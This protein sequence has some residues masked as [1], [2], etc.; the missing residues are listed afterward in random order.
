MI[1]S[2]KKIM[3]AVVGLILL[4]TASITVYSNVQL[5][6]TKQILSNVKN[7]QDAL[8][9][10]EAISLANSN[11]LIAILDENLSADEKRDQLERTV[12]KLNTILSKDEI[13]KR[14]D[15]ESIILRSLKIAEPFL[16][17]NII[18]QS[19]IDYARSEYRKTIELVSDLQIK[20]LE[21]SDK[22]YEMEENSLANVEFF[23]LMSS[24]LLI[25]SIIGLMLILNSL[26]VRPLRYIEKTIQSISAGDTFDNSKRESLISEIRSILKSLKN[27]SVTVNHAFCLE[28]MIEHM[29]VPVVSANPKDDFKMTYMNKEMIRTAHEIE[30]SMPI[31]VDEMIGNSIDVFHR[32]PGMIRKVLE[33][34]TNLPWSATITLGEFRMHLKISAIYDKKGEYSAIMLNWQNITEETKIIESFEK[35][36]KN[37]SDKVIKSSRDFSATAKQL[38]SA[39]KET[40]RMSLTVAEASDESTK[41]INSVAS[42]AEELS[43]SVSEINQRI[44]ESSKISSE[45]SE[46]AKTTNDKVSKL[47]E[48]ADAIGE[49]INLIKAIAEQTN[50]LALNATIEAARA[51]ES[52]KGF[53]VVAAE[54]KNLAN[55]TSKATHEISKQIQSIQEETKESVKNIQSIADIISQINEISSDISEAME[56][57]SQAT[58]EIASNAT[59]VAGSAEEVLHNITKVTSLSEE[60]GVASTNM[61]E[62][63][64]ELKENSN[65]LDKEVSQF[66]AMIKKQYGLK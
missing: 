18:D 25:S 24:V 62:S 56:E 35:S 10:L 64:N 34:P 59:Q 8:S 22:L 45:A 60:T 23:Y 21:D 52:G 31:S 49:V 27:L 46:Q 20:I 38:E 63:S 4:S 41:S 29:P 58:S 16:L 5:Q 15:I 11:T 57:Q 19:A 66:L 12:E 47:S 33:D 42:S 17:N 51:G 28:Q 65:I 43:S 9:Y 14:Y 39:A 54:V 26:I 53:A 30:K 3:I 50:L 40:A 61:L 44:A 2:I 55:Q 32:N 1:V 7:G 6:N 48:S 13:S 36:V 37:I